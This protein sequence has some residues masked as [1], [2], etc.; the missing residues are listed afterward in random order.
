MLGRHRTHPHLVLI[1]SNVRVIDLGP[2]ILNGRTSSHPQV[3]TEFVASKNQLISYLAFTSLVSTYKRAFYT[4]QQPMPP[5]SRE[6]KKKLRLNNSISSVVPWLKPTEMCPCDTVWL[7]DFLSTE[8]R[9]SMSVAHEMADMD[10]QAQPEWCAALMRSLVVCDADTRAR[11]TRVLLLFIPPSR[12]PILT[13]PSAS[14]TDPSSIPPI[15]N[16]V[17]SITTTLSTTTTTPRSTPEQSTNLVAQ[18]TTTTPIDAAT[19]SSL[20]TSNSTTA[21]TNYW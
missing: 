3:V 11:A 18:T 14:S 16:P 19:P 7:L 17:S 12:L 10:T 8:L 13:L 21:T 6:L 15:T 20:T 9:K 1:L 2:L 5:R 4:P